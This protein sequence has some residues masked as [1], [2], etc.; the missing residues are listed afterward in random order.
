ML[1]GETAPEVS[2]MHS[3]GDG[4]ARRSSAG[5]SNTRPKSVPAE[6]PR[7]AWN[8][9]SSSSDRPTARCHPTA[10]STS[11]SSSGR[12]SRCPRAIRL[13]ASVWRAITLLDRPRTRPAGAAIV[14]ALAVDLSVRRQSLGETGTFWRLLL[15]L[16]V[17]RAGYVSLAERLLAPLLESLNES[18]T[19]RDRAYQILDAVSGGGGADLRLYRQALLMMYQQSDESS[20]LTERLAIVSALA[21]INSRLGSYSQALRFGVEELELR[22]VL[23]HADHVD[24][25]AVRGKSPIGLGGRA[26]SRRR[27][28]CSRRCC[29]TRSGCSA[30]TTPTP[31]PP[32]ATSPI[33]PARRVAPKRP[34]PCSR[35]CCPTKSGCSAPTT[36]KPSRPARSSTSYERRPPRLL[37]VK[38]KQIPAG[39]PV[40]GGGGRS[41]PPMTIPGSDRIGV[42]TG[43]CG[44]KRWTG[45]SR[46]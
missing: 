3:R 38:P 7:P 35:R 18:E 46:N 28:P 27:W 9:S 36:P 20:D 41:R 22:L 2:R 40:R 5:G 25:L 13:E 30:P 32:G 42:G 34:W 17:G 31:S 24:T 19:T 10:R 4:P 6:T 1:P 39:L 16:H 12:S 29:P 11:R 45:A 15:A 33:G 44:T 21:N 37:K 14:D 26:T 8:R 23:F 43:V